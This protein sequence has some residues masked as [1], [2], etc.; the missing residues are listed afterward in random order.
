MLPGLHDIA[1]SD[2]FYNPQSVIS[3]FGRLAQEEPYIEEDSTRN[4]REKTR[5]SLQGR[6]RSDI[7]NIERTQIQTS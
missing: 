5:I 2:G 1:A 4:H 6:E 3:K 7:T